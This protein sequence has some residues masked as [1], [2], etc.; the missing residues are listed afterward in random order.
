MQNE[1]SSPRYG[2]VAM[3]LLWLTLICGVPNLLI[4][5]EWRALDLS[6]RGM[7]LL[8]LISSAVQFGYTFSASYVSSRTGESFMQM[9]SRHFG[10]RGPQLLGLL[11]LLNNAA[12]Y[13]LNAALLADSIA[14]LGLW[15]HNQRL[16]VLGLAIAMSLNNALG[17]RGVAGFARYIAGPMLI[18]WVGYTLWRLSGLP[19]HAATPAQ[20]PGV[21]LMLGT[22]SSFTIGAASWGNEADFWRHSQAR[23]R[24][25]ALAVGGS[26]LVGL[27]VF[28]LTGWLLATRLPHADLAQVIPLMTAQTLH[29]STGLALLLLTATYFA[30]ND[31]ILYGMVECVQY[32][33]PMSRAVTL[34]VLLCVNVLLSLL[35]QGY[36]RGLELVTA[37]SFI[38]LPAATVIMTYEDLRN[39]Y[40]G[41]SLSAQSGSHSS[42]A[43]IGFAA[44]VGVGLCCSGFIPGLR[45]LRGGVAPL[46]GWGAG[47][48]CYVLAKG[49]LRRRAARAASRSGPRSAGP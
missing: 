14:A 20:R 21:W 44:A 17:F 27:I 12:W 30:C 40:T 28:P 9:A 4:G 5:F 1:S 23:L 43:L 39:L 19:P 13:A 32:A 38:F 33:F 3:G 8:L 16:L 48:A 49:W 41:R 11:L 18:L 6:V 10:R 46:W 47:L 45:G 24:A 25:V 34:L 26:I 15:P 7:V 36:A 42:A 2:T 35:I 37:I 29:G 22:V 31:G